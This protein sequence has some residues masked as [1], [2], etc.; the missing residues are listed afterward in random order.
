M[1]LV[2]KVRISL[3]IIIGI[4][5]VFIGSLALFPDS[6]LLK[7][8]SAR[9]TGLSKLEQN[10][11]DAL[12]IT[13]LQLVRV[14]VQFDA[15]VLQLQD[16]V[17]AGRHR[18]VVLVPPRNLVLVQGEKPGDQTDEV[19]ELLRCLARSRSEVCF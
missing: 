8:E 18:V 11:G 15:Q 7:L 9:Q 14:H 4:I 16:N 17:L 1:D 2:R 6:R 13:S 19:D 3:H 10:L 5:G 12:A